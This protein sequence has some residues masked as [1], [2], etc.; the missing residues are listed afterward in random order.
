MKAKD[1]KV[2]DLVP[3]YFNQYRS[4]LLY[5]LPPRQPID[6]MGV[7]TEI[8]G[9]KTTVLIDGVLESWV[10]SDLKKMKAHKDR[11]DE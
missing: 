1:L 7:I 2:G 10:I 3:I 6:K 4:P 11:D 8:V 9:Y 5:Q